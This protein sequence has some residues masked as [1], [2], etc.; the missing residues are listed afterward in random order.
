MLII[1]IIIIISSSSLE[2]SF[3]FGGLLGSGTD[4]RAGDDLLC[5]RMGQVD[6]VS[7]KEVVKD[8]TSLD[9]PDLNTKIFKVVVE[10]DVGIGL[11]SGVV[12][13]GVNP[14]A[15]VSGVGDHLGAPGTLVFGVG[16]LRGLPFAIELI[17]PIVRLVGFRIR[18]GGGDGVPV[19]GFHIFG[20]G[21]LSSINPV[22]RLG[23]A[24]ILDLLGGEEAPV[25]IV[26]SGDLL[27]VDE[28]LVG[29][30]GLN[31]E[32][33]DVVILVSLARDGLGDHEVLTPVVEDDV[34]STSGGSTDIWTEH[35]GI[36]R[37]TVEVGLI[38][39]GR[40]QLDVSST[41]INV[42]LLLDGVLED[43]GLTMSGGNGLVQLG[44]NLVEAGVIICLETLIL[45]GIAVIF[46]SAYRVRSSFGSL[47]SGLNPSIKSSAAEILI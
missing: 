17:V 7:D 40:K 10:E 44:G 11:V 23:L 20:I 8:G 5:S 41:A 24:G 14:W 37:V 47:V 6:V 18:D 25:I 1:I 2:S 13:L 46:T 39:T 42:L 28:N 26:A 32:S 22:G 21:D 30:I 15:L 36:W 33:I 35:D 38:K 4:L 34:H 3:F 27:V 9:L 43:E 19:G 45:L 16:D 12:D 29:L 31:D